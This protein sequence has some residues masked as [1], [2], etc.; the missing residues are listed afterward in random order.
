MREVGRAEHASTEQLSAWLDG[1]AEPDERGFLAG[2]VEGCVV[3]SSELADLRSVRDLLRA[4]PVY[5]PPRSFTIPAEAA[6]PPARRFGRLIPLTRALG[7]VAAVLC[8]VLFS[9]DAMQSGYEAP[10]PVRDTSGAAMQNLHGGDAGR[11]GRSDG[12]VV[13]IFEVVRGDRA[14]G[15]R[16]AEGGER[17]GRP[18][19]P[20]S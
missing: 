1:R 15:R 3:C 4:L 19:G 9:V 10:A 2:H 6:R 20:G 17:A 7:T 13:G 18:T 12:R 11:I 14:A 8:V 5:L 16:R